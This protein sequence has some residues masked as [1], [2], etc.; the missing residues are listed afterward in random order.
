MATIERRWPR[1][2]RSGQV[3]WGAVDRDVFAHHFGAVMTPALFLFDATGNPAYVSR[4]AESISDKRL[5]WNRVR[6][7]AIKMSAM[8]P[9][10]ASAVP[11]PIT[12]RRILR[13]SAPKAMRTGCLCERGAFQYSIPRRR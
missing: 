6:V 4:S 2:A 1:L 11:W 9:P 8:M 5:A 3:T 7:A 10:R 12:N 13:G